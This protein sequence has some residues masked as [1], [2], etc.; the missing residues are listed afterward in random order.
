MNKRPIKAISDKPR[1]PTPPSTGRV[2]SGKRAP[3]PVGIHR[4]EMIDPHLTVLSSAAFDAFTEA[5]DKPATPSEGA[6]Q[7]IARSRQ[8]RR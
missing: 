2:G 1:S 8:W 3:A 6:R 7:A 4:L 5:L